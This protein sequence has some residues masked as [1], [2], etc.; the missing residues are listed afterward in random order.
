MYTII[1]TLLHEYYYEKYDYN[2]LLPVQ[3]RNEIQK[4]KNR[5]TPLL[6]VQL[7]VH[8]QVCTHS[9]SLTYIKHY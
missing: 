1:Y 7:H 6:E 9:L 2:T 4:K 3:P 5:K 8:A